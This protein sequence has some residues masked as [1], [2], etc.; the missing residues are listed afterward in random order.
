MS[1][2]KN[3]FTKFAGAVALSTLAM[4]QSFAGEPVW[5]A[6]TVE[7]ELQKIGKGVYAVYDSRA[8]DMAG[9]GVPMATSSGIIVGDDGVM[10]VDTMMNQR[11]N[12]QL[13]ALVKSVTDKPVKFAVNTSF[14]GD[15]SYGNYYLPESVT[16]IQHTNAKK[17]VDSHFE[18]DTKFMI[19]NF[20]ENRGI[21][22]VKA[23]T[24][25]ILIPENGQIN[26][27]LGGRNVLIKDFGFAQT[28]G[29][30]FVWLEEEKVI[31][32]GNAIVSEKPGLPWLLDGHLVAT[33]DTLQSVYDFLPSSALVIPGHSYPV[34]KSDLKWNIDYLAAVKNNVSSAVKKGLTLEETVKT[35]TMN[36]YRGYALFDWVHP[37]LNIPSAYKDLAQH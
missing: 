35:V 13:L 23:S 9:K 12:E 14:H 34:G 36:D 5:D 8:D 15:H 2:L 25:D 10:I 30:V 16:V 37:A 3:T 28:G 27:D 4:G 33:L 18:N 31:W 7:L 21:E 6:N 19:Q 20:G 26:V 29:D 22:E 1:T 32:M 11:L 24:G 17:Y